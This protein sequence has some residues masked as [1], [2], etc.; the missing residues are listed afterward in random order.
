MAEDLVR[1]K[2]IAA[3]AADIAEGF[4]FLNPLILKNF[5]NEVYKELYHQ[6]RKLQTV[7]RNEKFPF[8]DQE[9][10]RRRNLRLQ[11]LHQAIV[12]LQNAARVRKVAL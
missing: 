3:V 11:R 2:S 12:V 6:L 5:S 8:H 4:I 1:G 9:A 7:V 10:I